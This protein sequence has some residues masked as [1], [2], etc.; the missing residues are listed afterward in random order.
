MQCTLIFIGLVISYFFISLFKINFV[1][2]SKNV[3]SY[4][5]ER[6]KLDVTYWGYWLYW[7]AFRNLIHVKF[8]FLFSDKGSDFRLYAGPLTKG[9]TS[10][11]AVHKILLAQIVPEC[12]ENVP[13]KHKTWLLPTIQELTPKGPILWSSKSTSPAVSSTTVQLHPGSTV[14]LL[15]D[16]LFSGCFRFNLYFLFYFCE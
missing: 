6:L 15:A 9:W 1:K 12:L 14:D 16:I 7:A 8:I 5:S 4:T 13:Q 11:L 2:Y 3:S 10:Y